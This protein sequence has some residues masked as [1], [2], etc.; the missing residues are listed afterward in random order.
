[1]RIRLQVVAQNDG[2]A[3]ATVTEIAQFERTVFDAGSLGLHLEEAKALLSGLQRT[4]VAPQVA[5]AVADERLSDVR[6]SPC[7]QGAP[8][9]GLPLAV[10]TDVD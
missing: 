4:M 5:E 1:M 9:T 2:E 7:M 8:S 10:W 3:P 6:C